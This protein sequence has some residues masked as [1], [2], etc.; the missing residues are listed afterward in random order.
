MELPCKNLVQNGSP[1]EERKVLLDSF[2]V[3]PCAEVKQLVHEFRGFIAWVESDLRA[4]V[5]PSVDWE[6]DV[7][8]EAK[9]NLALMKL[10]AFNAA[11]APWAAIY[12][13]GPAPG[14]Q[15]IQPPAAAASPAKEAQPEQQQQPEPGQQPAQAASEAVD[16]PVDGSTPQ[17]SHPRSTINTSHNSSSGVVSM[18]SQMVSTQGSTGRFHSIASVVPITDDPVGASAAAAMT[19]PVP[20]S[21]TL[22]STSTGAAGAQDWGG[23]AATSGTAQDT[24]AAMAVPAAS[25]PQQPVQPGV[26]TGQAVAG[27]DGSSGSGGGPPPS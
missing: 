12:G 16:P 1:A 8:D 23:T 11:L 15:P 3:S 4:S 7:T 22:T 17:K 20:Q 6:V 25:A 2:C 9:E 10:D 26:P 18:G 14:E 21:V 19:K 13:E 24:Q 5:D 27:A